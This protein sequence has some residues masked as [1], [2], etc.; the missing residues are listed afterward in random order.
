MKEKDNYE[1]IIGLPHPDP[2]NHRRMSLQQRAA[3]FAPFAALEGFEDEI[4]A[5]GDAKEVDD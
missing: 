3:Q 1:D 5:V 2:T 4:R